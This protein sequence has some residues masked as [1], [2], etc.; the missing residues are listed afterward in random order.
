[1]FFSKTKKKRKLQFESLE[2]I[3]L[4]SVSPL[5]PMYEADYQVESGTP[6][7]VDAA[8][9]TNGVDALLVET[10]NS[11]SVT[12]SWE[13]SKLEYWRNSDSF[14]IEKKTVTNGVAKWDQVG[15]DIPYSYTIKDGKYQIQLNN[16]ASSTEYTFRLSYGS[17]ARGI[18]YSEE[19]TVK[20]DPVGIKGEAVSS[21]K[22]KLTWAIAAKNATYYS[23][24]QKDGSNWVEVGSVRADGTSATKT[25]TVENLDAATDYEFM[26]SYYETTAVT[27]SSQVSS[28]TIGV[29]TFCI[30]TKV[31]DAPK[32]VDFSWP[33]GL[34][35]T[36]YTIQIYTGSTAPTATTDW[37]NATGESTGSNGFHVTGLKE[38]TTYYFR[39]QLK[40][41]VDGEK[42]AHYSDVLNFSTPSSIAVQNVTASTAR[43]SWTFS[44]KAGTTAYVQL[45]PDG[46]ESSW[47][48]APGANVTGS[49]S[50]TLNNL[51]AGAVYFARVRYTSV[52][53]EMTYTAS[54]RFV[55]GVEATL[56][57]VT[58]DSVTITWNAANKSATTMFE[59]QRCDSNNYADTAIDANWKTII[60]NLG[61]STNEYTIQHVGANKLYY[62]RVAYTNTDGDR[63][64]TT[65]V[66]ALTN[67]VLQAAQPT[68]DTV[69]LDWNFVPKLGTTLTVQMFQGDYEPVSDA[70]WGQVPKAVTMDADNGGCLVT[71]LM[72]GK[73]YFFRILYTAENGTA[74]QKTTVASIYTTSGNLIASAASESSVTLRWATTGFA[75]IDA[76]KDLIIYRYE[77]SERTG[78]QV[79]KAV[80]TVSASQNSFTVTNLLADTDY[81]FKIGYVGESESQNVSIILSQ[82]TK[83]ATVSVVNVLKNSATLSWSFDTY[84]DSAK[85]GD[86][87]GR[88][89][90]YRYLGAGE[91]SEYDMIQMDNASIWERRFEENKPNEKS[92]NLLNLEMGSTQYYRVGYAY[93]NKIEP[94]EGATQDVFLT[95]KF[96]DVVKVETSKD[97]QLTTVSTNLAYIV[98][99]AKTLYSGTR[100]TVQMRAKNEGTGTF[101]GWSDAGTTSS[102]SFE[103]T[104]LAASTEYEF[105]VMFYDS[106]N[107]QKMTN[108][109]SAK[110]APYALTITSKEVASLAAGMT[111]TF[112][113][114]A[115]TESDFVLYYREKTSNENADWPVTQTIAGTVSGIGIVTVDINNL[116]PERE[117]EFKVVYKSN[118]SGTIVEKT[119]D[120]KTVSLSDDLIMSGITT[121]SIKVSWLASSFPD[122][123]AASQYYVQWRIAGTNDAWTNSPVQVASATSYTPSNLKSNTDYEI[124]VQFVTKTN[125]TAYSAIKVVRTAAPTI[126]VSAPQF[127]NVKIAWNF[128]SAEGGFVVQ[129]KDENNVWKNVAIAGAS[130]RE[131]VI[132]KVNNVDL[133]PETP[134][135]FRIL[136]KTSTGGVDVYSDEVSITTRKGLS[137]ATGSVTSSAVTIQWDY[138]TDI[139]TNFKLEVFEFGSNQPVF[140]KSDLSETTTEYRVTNLRQGTE[141]VFR[142]TYVNGIEVESPTVKTKTLKVSPPAPSNLKINDITSDSCRLT[143]SDNSEF[144]EG[145]AIE[146]TNTVTGY[147]TKLYSGPGLGMDTVEY[148]LSGLDQNTSYSVTVYAYN[149]EGKSV[150]AT[151]TFKTGD[152][153]RLNAVTSQKATT[154]PLSIVLTWDI[155]SITDVADPGR[156]RI[157]YYD[158]TTKYWY[159][160]A[161]CESLS[162]KTVSLSREIKYGPTDDL[163]TVT[164]ANNTSYQFRITALAFDASGNPI[165]DMNGRPVANATPV[166]ITAKTTSI[167]LPTSISAKEI[168]MASAKITFSD[169]APQGKTYTISYVE[170][171]YTSWASIPS[172]VPIKTE[173]I[174]TPDANSLYVII[175]DLVPKTVYSYIVTVT[176]DEGTA[177]SATPLS[178]TTASPPTMAAPGKGFTLDSSGNFGFNISWKAPTATTIPE[179]VTISYKIE[180]SADNKTYFDVTPSATP[181]FSNSLYSN[182]VLLSDV[183]KKMAALSTPVVLSSKTL[184]YVRIQA[185]FIASDSTELGSSISTVASQALP[186]WAK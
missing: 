130:Q 174:V 36:D 115:G 87:L 159:V 12:L 45:S 179:G 74:E 82:R 23:I 52:S 112:R 71:G 2:A 88:F 149:A 186:T 118:A 162:S 121:N 5:L 148:S 110:T 105:R 152:V 37:S 155:K 3:E 40:K 140:V 98:W 19:I 29:Q 160:V 65:V 122:K 16:L 183:S 43:V 9:Q 60:P 175:K 22:I 100:Y 10:K 168:T 77:F 123:L 144:E 124:R 30:L 95:R 49:Q 138:T 184:I 67:G 46:T 129:Y 70:G 76:T 119:T 164:F 170:G 151:T 68:I 133:E 126:S 141:Y 18:D 103:I 84:A 116:F 132:S 97:I 20:T 113:S 146:Y 26:I 109:L 142:L 114:I 50:Y 42:V 6:Q 177:Q 48:D 107:T 24:L 75:R 106:T 89:V 185:V 72:P 17:T 27:G 131:I 59:I 81:Q 66:T 39:L 178:F 35:G 173:T 15:T 150:V 64:Y 80:Q 139:G 90:V 25:Y 94:G 156:F 134:Y 8:F 61:N 7:N 101:S 180:M 38:N 117:Y 145:F 165:V 153:S 56:K 51:N 13:A 104:N 21:S 135:T 1:M 57:G 44:V 85:A 14:K 181:N 78:E 93:L 158:A 32:T 120:V 91:P 54:Q 63:V 28:Q 73:K 176:H 92:Y 136:Y 128:E 96:S 137:I 62:Y 172:S 108:V 102:T 169:T 86:G 58:S 111:V 79:W 182:I 4:M 53:G 69:K 47:Y 41:D 83:A 55:T 154:T 31:S 99:D 166:S 127:G 143:W 171:K 33:T 147:V 157:E 125:E 167:A 11:T 163:K 161:G 34:G